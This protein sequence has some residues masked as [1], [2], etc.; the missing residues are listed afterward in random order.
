MK[1]KLNIA[2]LGCGSITQYRHAPEC[3]QDDSIT[4]AGFYDRTPS[5]ARSFV[6]QYG[7]QVFASIDEALTAASV[8]AVIICLPNT[9]HADL[10][11]QALQHGKHVLCEKPM[12]TSLADCQQMVAT[13]KKCQRRLLVAHNQRLATINQRAKELLSAGTI[14]Q[15]LTFKTCFGHSG[16][17][18]WSVNKSNQT[19]FFNA[20]QSKYGAVFDLGIHKLDLIRYLLND[21]VKNVYGKLATLDKRDPSGNLIPVDDNAMAILEMKQGTIGTLTTSWTYYGAQDNSTTIYGSKG[22]MKINLDPA[23]PIQLFLNNGDQVDYRLKQQTNS[24]VVHEFAAAILHQRPSIL[25]A[26]QVLKSMDALFTLIRSAQV[27][28]PLEIE[29]NSRQ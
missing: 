6:S 12:A 17:E 11:I 5:R 24:A 9:M 21:D 23:K 1:K 8:D 16:P 20:H 27:G 18:N 3:A 26:D 2:I 7:G 28:H 15:P 22:T 4:I 19:W 13:A 29:D 14:G 25:D 10:A